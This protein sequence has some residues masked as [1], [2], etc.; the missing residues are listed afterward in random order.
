MIRIYSYLQRLRVP[1]NRS[2]FTLVELLIVIFILGIIMSGLF[3]TF[4]IGQFSFPVSSAKLELQSEARNTMNWIMKDLRQAISY[5]IANNNATTSYL[6]MNLWQW[7]TTANQWD[8][9]NTTNYVEYFYNSSSQN[10]TRRYTDASGN[11]SALNFTNIKEAPF[12]TNYT[13]KEL[14]TNNLLVNRKLIVV[15]SIEKA[16]RGTLIV[17]FTLISEV[18]IRNG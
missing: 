7:N 15:I 14:N 16:L 12:Y 1:N 9:S 4:N 17:P 8:I 2:A 5:N 10:L 11:V 6:K 13:A 3:L 18:K